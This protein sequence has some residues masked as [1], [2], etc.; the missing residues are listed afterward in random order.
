MNRR[1]VWIIYVL[2][3]S[4]HYIR[5]AR[6]PIKNI[7]QSESAVTTSAQVPTNIQD[8][9]VLLNAQNPGTKPS[10]ETPR[11]SA[12]VDESLARARGK[13]SGEISG[14][15]GP[16]IWTEDQV[17]EFHFENVGL[18]QLVTQIEQI[19]NVKFITDDVLDPLPAGGK[20]LK[21][22]K[23]TFKTN[24]PL[25][26][27]DAWNLFISFLGLAD[28]N[29]IPQANRSIYRIATVQNTR[30]SSLP[31]FIGVDS[32]DL[33]DNDQLVRYIYFIEN[34]T[35]DV[36]NPVVGALKSPFAQVIDLKETNGFIITDKSYNIKAL[37]SIIKELDKTTIPQ[38]MSILKLRRVEAEQ[39]KNLYET[40]TQSGDKAVI[41]PGPRRGPVS[42]YFPDNVRII[43]EPRTNA[44]V[45]LGPADA[46]AK[47]EDFIVKHVDVELGTK[48]SDLT[49]H[50]LR[51]ADA[52]TVANIMNDMLK[53]G[54]SSPAAQFGGLRGPDK[55]VRPMTFTPEPSTNRLIIKG[56]Q[57]D[58]ELIKPIID[59]LDEPQQQVSVEAL[60]LAIDL[61]NDKILGTQIHNRQP[62]GANGFLN[63]NIKFQTSGLHTGPN[64]SPRGIIQNPN[65]PGVNRLLGNLIE[66]VNNAS[67]TAGSTVISFGDP[68]SIWGIFQILDRYSNT[69]VVANPFLTATNKTTAE[70]KVSEVRRVVTSQVIGTN[71][72]E[73]FG[74]YEA[75]LVIRVTPQINAD[76][77]IIL[78]LSIRLENF[79]GA[80]VATDV[81]KNVRTVNTKVLT[82]DEGVIAI[83][84]LV[85][86]RIDEDIIKVPVLGDIPGFGWLFKNKRQVEVKTNLLV[87]ISTRIIKPTVAQGIDI[88]TE[89]R[90]ADYHDQLDYIHSGP[91]N[92]DPI[93]RWFFG[94]PNQT[95]L[96]L[97]TFLFDRYAQGLAANRNNLAITSEEQ[98][99]RPIEP[100]PDYNPEVADK[101]IPYYTRKK[102]RLAKSQ[103][104]R[105]GASA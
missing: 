23:L 44:L 3:L 50:T 28:F 70:V 16:A 74:S 18:D 6:T 62:A 48:Y 25:T 97:E 53:L 14:T 78:D 69:E 9:S 13:Q 47:I 101:K 66:L 88:V 33:P 35:T 65:G 38:S 58:Y 100:A 87:L 64:Y 105:S 71:T 34:S 75:P 85:R 37:M 49:V 80:L 59:E 4:A 12:E 43:V 19:F 77:T 27:Q 84:G 60:I 96:N 73:A 39:V 92:R 29:L 17:V 95:Q 94:V 7:L 103:A 10:L 31:T 83:G 22:N 1:I 99:P 54:N 52:V 15:Q 11:V 51:Y 26:K 56:H 32:A 68:V 41:R 45:L 21:G 36:L 93:S 79:I 82:K 20:S 2:S 102:M 61:N 40:L 57:Q 30:N 5:A 98:T 91:Q 81:R 8:T 72:T 42:N 89:E 86:N 24:S 90:I 76:G 63:D 55:F 46:I 104:R 67:T